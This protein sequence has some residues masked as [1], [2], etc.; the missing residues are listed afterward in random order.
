MS[1][2]LPLYAHAHREGKSLTELFF[3]NNLYLLIVLENGF[4]NLP[5]AWI[6]ED[7]SEVIEQNMTNN[8]L[9][10]LARE[11]EISPEAMKVVKKLRG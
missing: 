1:E 8:I 3:W 4:G 2:K 6:S 9:A 11:E 5:M 10:T 7:G